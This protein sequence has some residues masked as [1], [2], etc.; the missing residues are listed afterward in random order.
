V[1]D[2]NATVE[3]VLKM[4]RRL[5]GEEIHLA[6]LPKTG[7]G[8]I[9]MDPSQLDQILA[10][11]C[12]NS[13]DA[14]GGVG[15]ITIET[16]MVTVD[17][18]YC[19]VH[20]GFGPGDYVL[21]TVSD[22]GCGMDKETLGNVFEPFFTTKEV[23]QG[24]GL[25]LATV[26]GIVKQ[27]NG[28]INVYSE[29]GQGTIFRI[30][31]PLHEKGIG[32]MD[33]VSTG[34]VPLGKGQTILVVEDEKVVLRLSK[35]MLEKLGYIVLAANT[36]SDALKLAEADE[37]TID[38]LITDVVMPEMNGRELAER[39]HSFQPELKIIYM[40]G[41]TADVIAHR[42]VLEEGVAFIGKPFSSK[43]LAAKVNEVLKRD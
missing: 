20:S 34:E 29:P 17:D 30:Y 11:L 38:L 25:G 42:G 36:P 21:L 43:E 14:I 16:D 37:N 13:R 2:L 19:V 3:G 27:N 22:D 41:Y 32:R 15:K 1:L 18:T 7:L 31:L 12:I 6:W 40:S 33:A 28:F 26:Y 23:G 35:I 39:L 24:T 10:N 9:K 4:L 5:L 8:T